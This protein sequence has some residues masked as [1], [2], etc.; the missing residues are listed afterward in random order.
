MYIQA[1]Q[2]RTYVPISTN[3]DLGFK[4]YPNSVLKHYQNAAKV[5]SFIEPEGAEKYDKLRDMVNPHPNNP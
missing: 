4:Y 3:K 2:R 5:A 1:E